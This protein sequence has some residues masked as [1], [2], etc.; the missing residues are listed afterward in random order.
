LELVAVFGVQ[1][2][3]EGPP[4]G[5][6]VTGGRSNAAPLAG[7]WDCSG[8]S[9]VRLGAGRP[10]PGDLRVDV[11]RH[12]RA[13][14]LELAPGVARDAPHDLELVAIGVVAVERPRADGVARAT[15]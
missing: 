3:H 8:V 10:E 1:L 13:V 7:G 12:H 5:T 11:Q 14:L 4:F 6:M 2:G 15:A 9:S